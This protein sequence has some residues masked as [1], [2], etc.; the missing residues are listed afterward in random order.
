VSHLKTKEYY[1][2]S[3]RTLRKYLYRHFP[4]FTRNRITTGVHVKVIAVGEG[5]ELDTNSER[6]WIAEPPASELSS[7]VIIYGPKVALISVS[8]DETPYGV[9]IEEPGVAAMQRLLFGTL[10]SQLG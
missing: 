6:R 8:A 9:V 10:W 2:Y 5:G 1:A 7:Y 4:N 3:S